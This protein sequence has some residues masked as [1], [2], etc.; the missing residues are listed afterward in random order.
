M[1]EPSAAPE[2]A[3]QRAPTVGLEQRRE[4]A[5]AGEKCRKRNPD[6]GVGA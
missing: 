1:N 4:V 2:E 5:V 6:D 3:L